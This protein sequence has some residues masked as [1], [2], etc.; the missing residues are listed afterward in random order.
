VVLCSKLRER[1]FYVA[2]RSP[3]NFGDSVNASKGK[4]NTTQLWYW[5]QSDDD[6]N[7]PRNAMDVG[8]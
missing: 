7:A 5:Q 6:S 4:K 8:L 2:Q 1:L 3:K